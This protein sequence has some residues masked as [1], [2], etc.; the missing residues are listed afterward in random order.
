MKRFQR[1]QMLI[2]IDYRTYRPLSVDMTR[3]VNADRGHLAAQPEIHMY[4]SGTLST[5]GARV[6]SR[7]VCALRTDLFAIRRQ[8]FV[9]FPSSLAHLLPPSSTDAAASNPPGALYVYSPA[10]RAYPESPR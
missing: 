10:T 2:Q 3:H 6:T 4:T 7:I 9:I 5:V 8:R 1:A